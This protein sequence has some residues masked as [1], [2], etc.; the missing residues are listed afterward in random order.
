M[1]SMGR[2]A[3][4]GVWVYDFSL[5]RITLLDPDGGLD[6]VVTLE[7]GLNRLN[8]LGRSLD[9]GFVLAQSWSPERLDATKTEGLRRDS[10]VYARFA[11][12]GSLLDTL[13]LSLGREIALA[14]DP[15][16]G[17]MTMGTP[18]FARSTERV[19]TD[20]YLYI[21]E[22]N[23]YE[24]AQYD[25]SGRLL[26]LIRMPA[27]DLHIT[28]AMKRDYKEAQIIDTPQEERAG[29]REYLDAIPV[30]PSLPAHGYMR[31]DS[32]SRLWVSS[33]PAFVGNSRFFDVFGLG[34]RWIT[35]VDVPDGFDPMVIGADW[36]LGVG[37]DELGVET[38]RLYG[39]ARLGGA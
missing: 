2:S 35:R 21:G 9:G 7:P 31:V 14:V 38:V 13:V 30:A 3:N 22:E 29:M 37:R 23:S 11:P 18:P 5:R 6:A 4:G 1:A 27:V 12:D 20:E 19:M 16:S 10:V 8:M 17:R 25:L 26:R 36:V 33:Y 39:L 28:D 34:G 32:E 15:S 24:I